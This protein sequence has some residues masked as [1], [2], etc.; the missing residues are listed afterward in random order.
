MREKELYGHSLTVKEIS[1]ITNYTR[2]TVSRKLLKNKNY[3]VT[4]DIKMAYSYKLRG[5]SVVVWGG[6]FEGMLVFVFKK[7]RLNVRSLP[8]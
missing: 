6:L 8:F 7:K 5:Y 3:T 4:F 1:E 2:E